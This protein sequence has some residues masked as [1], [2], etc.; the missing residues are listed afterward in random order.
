MAL[1]YDS[2]IDLA[3]DRFLLNDPLI[4][5]AVFHRDPFLGYLRDAV[6]EKF[7]GG[8]RTV[9]SVFEYDGETAGAYDIGEEF[10]I[11]ERRA[12]DAFGLPMQFFYGNLTANLEELEV[13][14]QGPRQQYDW[15]ETRF[16]RVLKTL[17]S[18]LSAILYLDSQQANHGRLLAGMAEAANDGVNA[19]YDGVTYPT[20]GNATR[21]GPEILDALNSVPKPTGATLQLMDLEDSHADASLGEGDESPNIGVTTFKGFSI[22]K[23]RFQSQQ[24]FPNTTDPKLNFVAMDFN[25]TRL[26]RSRF[27]PGTFIS[28]T[29]TGGFNRLVNAFISKSTTGKVTAYPT[30]TSETLWWLNVRKQYMRFLISSSRK[31]SFGWTGFKYAQGNTKVVGQILLSCALVVRSPRHQKQVFGFS[32]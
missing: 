12:E 28:G 6:E 24:R 19:S 30:V 15:L 1:R 13:F 9:E 14:N 8:R 26:M 3:I 21:N 20:Y 10:D 25:N 11:T 5:D 16:A 2:Q 23:S 7:T 22:I 27:T 29:G 32:R 17:G 31:Y 4:L 18:G